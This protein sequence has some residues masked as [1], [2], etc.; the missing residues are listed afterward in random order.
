MAPLLA[1]ST[2]RSPINSLRTSLDP[3]GHSFSNAVPLHTAAASS[4]FIVANFRCRSVSSLSIRLSLDAPTPPCVE[5]HSSSSWTLL[6]TDVT[7]ECTWQ[8]VMV[9]DGSGQSYHVHSLSS[10]QAIARSVR[11]QQ[12]PDWRRHST[13]S[14]IGL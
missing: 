6:L 3:Q 8:S 1:T 14:Q 5:L 9:L 4:N 11:R 2:M 12:H 7:M 13:A 10:Q